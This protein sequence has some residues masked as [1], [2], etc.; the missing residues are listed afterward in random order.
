VSAADVGARLDLFVKGRSEVAAAVG[1]LSRAEVQRLIDEGQITVNGRSVK[2]S[3]RL[4][5]SDWV[6]I[7][8]VPSRETELRS[9]DLPLDILFEDDDCIV[10]NKA[11]GMV[12][13]PGAGQSTGTLVNALLHHCPEIEGIGG[14]RRPGIVHR[15]DKD[16]SG[17]MIIAKNGRAFRHLALQ[18]KDRSVAKE[19]LAI[20]QGRLKPENGA[21]DR[22]I[23]R[24]RSDRKK[25]S[26][27]RSIPRKREALTA[28]R[29]EE[30]LRFVCADGKH[31][32]DLTLVRVMPRTGRTHQIRVH[33]A[34]LG[35]P[36]VGDRIYGHPR[37]SRELKECG[38]DPFSR[39]ALHAE[40]L[41]I[42][43]PRSNETM[44]FRAPLAKDMKNWIVQF[45]KDRSNDVLGVDKENGFTYY[46]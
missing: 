31:V 9:E 29:V 38:S 3:T 35:F 5:I 41:V 27:L 1:E 16:T 32:S 40:K 34:D 2:P 39:Q 36:I 21:I 6:E 26:S 28:W 44:E 17:V 25:M 30:R 43:H 7:K 22:P 33:L 24:H 23:G 46:N 15:L 8:S 19:Y 18:F 11:P 14:E 45:R 20:V 12:V 10:I 13:H 37:N 42:R 4:K